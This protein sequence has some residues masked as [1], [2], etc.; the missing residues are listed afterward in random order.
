MNQENNAMNM[1]RRL[2]GWKSVSAVALVA[3]ICGCN[4]ADPN[5]SATPEPEAA[6]TSNRPEDPP[7]GAIVVEETKHENA[8]L[9]SRSEG[10]K[11][12]D[13]NLIR[14]GVST[15]WYENGDK[16]SEQQFSHGVPHGP[17]KTWYTGGRPW[18]QGAYDHGAED[19]TWSDYAGDGTMQTEWHMKKGAWH[20][21]YTQFH[22]N[23][24]KRLEV[25]F[26]EGKRQG[27]SRM[28]DEQGV[29]ALETDYVDGVEQP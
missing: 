6:L 13:G 2:E 23:G 1:R 21:I 24:K 28:Y 19:G 11:D 9:K 25:E 29:L 15:I 8:N 12:S 26:V 22:P 18:S 4:S 27:P 10:Y 5:D 3:A 14:H 17:R 16:K 7:K 20:G